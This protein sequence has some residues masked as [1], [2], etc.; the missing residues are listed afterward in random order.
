MAAEVQHGDAVIHGID[1][2]G[3]AITVSGY[4]TFF[5]QSINIQQNFEEKITKDNLGFD[6]NWTSLNE[7]SVMKMKFRPKGATRAAASAV[8]A[9]VA[10]H[11][12]VTTANFKVAALNGD[13]QN[14]S[15]ATIDLKNDDPAD[16]ELSLRKYADSTQNTA[17]TGT[18]VSG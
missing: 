17:A 8:A 7:H 9:F 14:L 15:G 5:L 6:A 13:F 2:S 1:N 11:A 4:A 12:K 3:S 10:P 16:Q 18:A